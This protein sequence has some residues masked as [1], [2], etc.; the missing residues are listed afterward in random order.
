MAGASAARVG[1]ASALQDA[2]GRG[3]PHIVA[4]GEISGMPMITLSEGQ[5]LWGG[6]LRF[7]AC[8]VRL[9]RDNV[10]E[11]VT[12]IVPEHER[13]VLN[14]TN[15]PDWGRLEVRDVQTEGQ[16]L[17][18][19]DGAARAGHVVVDGL[20]VAAADGT[21]CGSPA[22]LA[23]LTGGAVITAVNGQA[24]GS[25]DDLS[26]IMTRFHPGDTISVTWV[27]PSGKRTTS[28]LRLT[29]GPPQ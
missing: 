15:V 25:P 5:R 28:S 9:T 22:A 8:G 18:L 10:L 3:V 13:A 6:T 23:G 21:I 12:I 19:A 17:L 7:G 16:V 20:H 26:G 24:V 27:S 1:D 14:D 29:A 4:E 2:I 11:G